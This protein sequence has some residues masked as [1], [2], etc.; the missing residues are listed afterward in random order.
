METKYQIKEMDQESFTP[1]F[2]KYTKE[3]FDE[4]SQVFHLREAL[5]DMEKDK[6]K[7][8][9]SDLGSPYILRLGIFHNDQF[10][11]WHFGY[12]ESATKFY[13]CNSGILPEHRRKGLYTKLL[14]KTL[15]ILEDKGF[16]EIYSR[17]M[18]TN[19]E[20]I[21]PKLKSGFYITSLALDDVFGTLVHLTYHPNKLRKKVLNYRTGS[22]KPDDEIRKYLKL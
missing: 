18:P 19:N 16:Q 15:K 14:K 2:K 12:Q 17:H 4:V 8:L 11:G 6:L 5:S 7:I 1:L 21:I 10:C 20:V 13:M 9:A 22:I 3:F